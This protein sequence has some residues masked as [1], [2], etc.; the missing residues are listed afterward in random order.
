MTFEI[1]VALAALLLAMAAIASGLVM[2]RVRG[3]WSL[4]SIGARAGGAAVLAGALITAAIAKGEWSPLDPRQMVVGLLLAML[5]IHLVLVWRLRIGDAGPAVDVA[6]LVL[7]LGGAFAMQPG[8]RLLT[9]AQRT[10]PFQAQWV[11]FLLG[12]G[13]VLVGGNAGLMVALH[14]GSRSRGWDVGLPKRADLYDLLTQ[15]VFLA[16]VVLGGGL[17]VSVWWAWRTVG[18]LTGGDPHQ[19]AVAIVW[20]VAGMSL[21]AWKLE[22]HRGRWATGL[23]ILAAATVLLGLL[24]AAAL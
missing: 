21:L 12:G 1:W 24:G 11:L 22:D 10:I 8:A 5:V 18:M 14:K 4:V 9:C 23:A 19:G 15:A 16:M 7:I 13:S 6:A 3:R 17:T 2:F 20:L